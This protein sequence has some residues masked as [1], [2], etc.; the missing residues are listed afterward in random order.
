M[1]KPID[2]RTRYL[3]RQHMI[4]PARLTQADV[5]RELELISQQSFYRIFYRV[6]MEGQHTKKKSV[7]ITYGGAK[8]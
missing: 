8:E 6:I 5:M 1:A 3:M 2:E 7:K 4:A